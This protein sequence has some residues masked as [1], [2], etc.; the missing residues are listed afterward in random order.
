MSGKTPTRHALEALLGDG[1]WHSM[2]EI[3]QR[4]GA[5]VEIRMA[6]RIYVGSGV[7]KKGGREAAWCL[8]HEDLERRLGIGCREYL[9]TKLIDMGAESRG[10]RGLTREYRLPLVAHLPL[11]EKGEA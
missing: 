7:D 1:Q 2:A 8:L 4:V 11:N 6:A 9:H 5:T 10:P 3:W